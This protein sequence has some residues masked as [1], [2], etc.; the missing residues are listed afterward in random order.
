[1]DVLWKESLWRQFGA[2]IDTLDAAINTCPDSLWTATL[3]DD[4]E[5]ARY[6]Q[7]WYIAYHTLSWLDLFLA[8]SGEGF[9]PP[10]PFIRGALPQAPY[11]KADVSA[12]LQHGRRKC[13]A[14]IDALT[15]ERARQVCTFSWMQP[16]FLELQ[17]YNLRHVQEH[18]AHLNLF[19]GGQGLAV[20]DWISKVKDES[21]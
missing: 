18:A 19:L 9:A 15:D 5:D 3:W 13:R 17:F 20:T 6:G 2:A 12:Y 11:T 8:G 7:F 14:T 21:V 4:T 1:M 16:T 10:A